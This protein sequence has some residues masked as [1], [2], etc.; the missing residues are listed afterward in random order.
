M[1]P[2][3]GW[4][5]PLIKRRRKRR[6]REWTRQATDFREATGTTAKKL[7]EG[8][9][10]DP[11]KGQQPFRPNPNGVGDCTATLKR[12]LIGADFSS[13]LRWI[14]IGHGN[15]SIVYKIQWPAPFATTC[16]AINY[17][18]FP[19]PFPTIIWRF[20]TWSFFSLRPNPTFYHINESLYIFS[21]RGVVAI[22]TGFESKGL[23][24]KFY[25][26]AIGV[27]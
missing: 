15:P 27:C 9:N 26:F 5:L 16:Q 21:R 12:L 1:G 11:R 6:R 10:W 3:L 8:G 24:F 14:A 19:V 25:K 22:V 2:G 4:T 23:G 7:F 13:S 20:T 18:Y 17:S